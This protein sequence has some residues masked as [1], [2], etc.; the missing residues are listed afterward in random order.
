M[1]TDPIFLNEAVKFIKNELKAFFTPDEVQQLVFIIFEHLADITKVDIISGN[2]RII[3]ASKFEQITRMV[4][5]LKKKMPVEYIVGKTRF[6]YL[7]LKVSPEVLIPRPETEELVDW[8]I[9]THNSSFP[10]ILDIGTG[11]G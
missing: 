1:S 7:D 11:S 6:Y 9:K 2:N 3:S 4:F 5:L 10:K 8:I